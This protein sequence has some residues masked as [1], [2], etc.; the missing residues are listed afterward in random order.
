MRRDKIIDR[1]L[2]FIAGRTPFSPYI[3]HSARLPVHVIRIGL[4][5]LYTRPACEAAY[6]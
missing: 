1:Y 5:A 2:R 3:Q 6:I 4:L